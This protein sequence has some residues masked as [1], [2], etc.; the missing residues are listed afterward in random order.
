MPEYVRVKCQSTKHE[1]S[2]SADA[3]R[4]GWDV[5]DKPAT[6]SDG[7]PLPPKHYVAPESLSSKPKNGHE[8][9]N[10]KGAK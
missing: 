5:I 9:D 8:A 3:S 4:E 7:T 6:Q 2:I 1:M 10:P